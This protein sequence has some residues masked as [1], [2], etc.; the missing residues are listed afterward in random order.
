MKNDRRNFL[1]ITSLSAAASAVMPKGFALT[2][3]RTPAALSDS[4]VLIG[5]SAASFRPWIGSRFGLVDRSSGYLVLLSVDEQVEPV[6]MVGAARVVGQTGLRKQANHTV[7]FALHFKI[8]GIS[9]QLKQETYLLTHNG[10][11]R[12]PLFLVPSGDPAT[13]TCS[14]QFSAPPLSARSVIGGPTPVRLPPVGQ[15]AYRSN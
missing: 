4:T 12:F 10:L 2:A 1:K 6:A 15:F 7:S 13:R 11:G 3:H 5:L 8:V 9:N 14:A